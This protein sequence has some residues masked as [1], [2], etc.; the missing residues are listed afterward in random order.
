[1]SSSIA[2]GSPALIRLYRP[3]PGCTSVGL[4]S[5]PGPLTC[6]SGSLPLWASLPQFRGEGGHQGDERAVEDQRAG[7]QRDASGVNRQAALKINAYIERVKCVCMMPF[8][9]PVVPDYYS[10]DLQRDGRCVPMCLPR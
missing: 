7:V 3:G 8:G 5:D 10:T 4:P 9:S 1:M 2:A 6:S